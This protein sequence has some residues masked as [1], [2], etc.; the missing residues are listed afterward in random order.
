MLAIA[1]GI[2]VGRGL[3]DNA[4]AALITRGFAEMVRLAEAQGRPGRDPDGPLRPRRSDAHLHQPAV[5]QLF[6]RRWRSAQGETL[7]A[8][9]AARR[10]VAEG[11]TSAPAAVA[12]AR[13]LGIE[14]PIA[15]AVDAILHAGAAIDQVIEGLLV[16]AVP[17]GRRRVL[18]PPF[19]AL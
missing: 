11:V 3:G 9:L 15:T 16:A 4:R 7:A 1:C 19:I 13:R 14:M 17:H 6:A 18:T 10:S 12:L 8:I 2:V 5:A